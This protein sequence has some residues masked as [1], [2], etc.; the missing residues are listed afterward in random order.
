VPGALA[1]HIELAP[2]YI[3]TQISRHRRDRSIYIVTVRVTVYQYRFTGSTSEKLIQRRIEVLPL[4][5]HS[6][7]ST[8]L[9]AVIVTGPAPISAF[10]KVLPECLRF[11]AHR[12]QSTA[13]Q[14]DR[15]DNWLAG[16]RPFNVA[17]HKP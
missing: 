13:E 16:S 3:P 7:V 1:H 11:D 6:A 8:A 15:L 17:S 10:A 4:I 5:S 12:G 14:D 2:P 9:I